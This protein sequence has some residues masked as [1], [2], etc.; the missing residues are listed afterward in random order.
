MFKKTMAVKVVR[1]RELT[2]NLRDAELEEEVDY[3][4][5]YCTHDPYI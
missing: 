2:D 5:T 1:H 4:I 3:I